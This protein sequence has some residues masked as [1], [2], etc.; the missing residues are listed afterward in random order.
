MEAEVARQDWRVSLAHIDV[1]ENWSMEFV[2][3]VNHYPHQLRLLILTLIT[4]TS[5][6]GSRAIKYG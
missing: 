5:Q 3:S 6:R 1:K 4:S 2:K